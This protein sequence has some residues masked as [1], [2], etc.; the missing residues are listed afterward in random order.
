M[1]Q[2]R[3]R[4]LVDLETGGPMKI[5]P[6]DFFRETTLRICGSLEIEKA[7]WQTLLYVNGF[8]PAYQMSLH[9][10]DLEKGIVETVAHAD[11]SG[12]RAL[13]VK[14]KYS[15]RAR[16][17]AEKRSKKNV[18]IF[19]K[20]GDD[21]VV[22][23]LAA[24]F[25]ALDLSGM[26]VS[27]SLEGRPLGILSVFNDGEGKLTQEHGRLLSMV[28]EPFAIALTNYLRYRELVRNKDRL[29]DDN[30]YLRKE[31][32]QISGEEVIGVDLGLK[33]VME[34]AGQ[35]APLDSPVLLLGETGTGKEVIARTIHRLSPR[36]EGPFITVNCGAIPETLMDSELFGHEKG[37]F[38]GAVNEKRG[39]FERADGGTIFLDEIG[40]L[41]PDAQ[42]RLLRV[43]QER[44]IE[45]V[46][47]VETFPVDIRVIAATHR[48]LETMLGNNQF[49]E[50]LYFRLR[51]FPIHIPPL[52]ER[53]EDIPGLVR[54]V[55]R[56]KAREMKLSTVPDLAPGALDGLTAYRWPGNVREMENAVERALILNRRGPLSFDDLEKSSYR[57]GQE[58]GAPVQDVWETLDR[59]MAA[60][61]QKALELA[62]GKVEGKGGA[63]ERLGIH[64]T[65]LR[66]R[67]KKRGVPMRLRSRFTSL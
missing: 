33:K 30:L 49:R 57:N 32:Q 66:H 10:Y 48:D 31:I 53:R 24:R 59:A 8:L 11:L 22:R 13:S 20:M 58:G 52:R 35:V 56:K 19:E 9:V 17:I 7:L 28:N 5:D 12:G 47:G 40:E 44:E 65:T 55:V 34:M 43:L 25:N 4:V 54:H 15:Q 27:L 21:E 18:W 62:G 60:Y 36:Q 38:T 46:G 2:K 61:M 67:M 64:P 14:V 26:R 50:D 3:G 45:R 1:R 16:K 42:V 37:A 39:R 23:P 41:S 29:A 63:A 6:K 51:V